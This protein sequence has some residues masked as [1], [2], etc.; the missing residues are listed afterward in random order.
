MDL[1]KSL[2][3]LKC[4]LGCHNFKLLEVTLGFGEAGDVE[5][6]ECSRCSLVISREKRRD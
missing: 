1:A 3:R 5:K 6:V 2:D 4:W